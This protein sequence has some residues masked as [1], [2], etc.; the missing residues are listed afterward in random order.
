MMRCAATTILAAVVAISRAGCS[1]GRQKLAPDS[2]LHDV[3]RYDNIMLMPTIGRRSG[4][5]EDGTSLATGVKTLLARRIVS[6]LD[7]QGLTVREAESRTGNAAADFSRLRQGQLERFSIERLLD[8]ASRLGERL[9]L[10]VRARPGEAK[11]MAPETLAV[12]LKPL[13]ALCR[14]FMVR[15]LSAFGSV[16]RPDFDAARSDI[17]LAVEFGPSRR[18]GPADQYFEFKAAVERLVGRPVDLVEM[19]AMADSRLKRVIE[20]TQVPVYEQAA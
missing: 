2:I 9:T 20:R 13:R 5:E 6:A 1:V 3:V 16:L 11:A 18:Y 12:H 17:D 7:R 10:T 8:M 19:K 14:R 4:K 15:R